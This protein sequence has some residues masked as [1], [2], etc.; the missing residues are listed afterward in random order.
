MDKA[1][2]KPDRPSRLSTRLKGYDYISRG[3]YFVTICTDGHMPHFANPTF[4]ALF[5]EVWQALP[6]RFPDIAIDEFVVM[7]DH[8]H[9]IIWLDGTKEHDPALG[10]IIGAYKS[11]TTVAWLNYHKKLGVLCSKHLWQN[12]FYDHI[13][14]NDQDLERTRQYILDNP[15]KQEQR[16]Q[17]ARACLEERCNMD[18]H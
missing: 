17:A 10:Q 4:Y 3:A 13:I 6:D 8:V 9:G 16:E 14:R 18:E 5:F 7:P 15:A 11:I 12:G 2:N 1:N